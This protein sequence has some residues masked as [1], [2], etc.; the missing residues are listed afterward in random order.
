MNTYTLATENVC[1]YP[2][3]SLYIYDMYSLFY[4]L[5]YIRRSK[6]IWNLQRTHEVF[7]WI[8]VIPVNNDGATPVPEKQK[9]L[10]LLATHNKSLFSSCHI[11]MS[12]LSN[13]L[14]NIFVLIARCGP[15]SND[16]ILSISCFISCSKRR[17][18][19]DATSIS[20]C[21]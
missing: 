18:I 5:S 6:H 10:S 4:N 14:G 17:C 11:N 9:N 3:L 2:S 20:L 19:C 1:M 16:D 13:L 15:D 21:C 7:P 8:K 12:E